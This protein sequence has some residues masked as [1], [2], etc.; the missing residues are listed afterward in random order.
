MSHPTPSFASLREHAL[1]ARQRTTRLAGLG[2]LPSEID[3]FLLRSP[4]PSSSQVAEFLKLYAGEAR[5]AAARALIAKGV[6]RAAV[7]NALVWLDAAGRVKWSSIW[8]I[9][10][11]I[12][13]AASAF[14]GYRRNQSIG[15]A[16]WWGIMGGVFPIFTPVVALAQGFGKRKGVALAGQDD[17]V[18]LIEAKQRRIENDRRAA[19]PS[20][21][22]TNT[23][24]GLFV[25][26]SSPGV[27]Y[28]K[29]NAVLSVLRAAR[30]P[31]GDAIP[32]NIFV[33]ASS[34]TA[35]ATI[36]AELEDALRHAGYRV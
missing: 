33:P 19:L 36:R 26:V 32:P 24:N 8:G 30:I 11:T 15:W 7:A 23:G 21:A 9:A 2:D 3:G 35:K 27:G 10:A 29:Y 31:T 17:S 1:E 20:I 34:A 25:R 28:S 18:D 13:S 14:H 5:N 12:S 22:V 4:R 16:I 6:D